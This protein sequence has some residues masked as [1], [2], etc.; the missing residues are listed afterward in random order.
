[1]KISDSIKSTK[2]IKRF[3]LLED[4]FN[5]MHSFKYDYSDTVYCG[6][7]ENITYKCPKHGKVTQK[8]ISHAKGIGCQRCAWENNASERKRST[9]EIIEKCNI[10]HC[11]FYDYSLT[12]YKG[13]HSKI[14]IICPIHGE[15]S[16]L[17]YAHYNG[18]GCPKCANFKR[19]ETSKYDTY[20]NVPTTLYYI[21]IDKFYKIGLTQSSLKRRF[22]NK[23]D[24]ITVIKTW[25]FDD[26]WEAFLL[27]QYVLKK[28]DKFMPKN[29]NLPIN[30]GKTELRTIDVIDVIV[31]GIEDEVYSV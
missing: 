7:K 26:G 22:G 11:N 3:V 18:Q 6:M 14:D 9:L 10:T 29:K 4:Q 23:F 27:E 19:V 8:A 12:N 17:A 24:D 28:T 30:E 21:K 1:M 16:Q 13:T 20:K 15:F 5:K 31:E 2:S 25:H